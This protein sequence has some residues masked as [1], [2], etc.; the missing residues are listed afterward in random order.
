VAFSRVSTDVTDPLF[1]VNAS[2]T[3]SVAVVGGADLGILLES[4]DGGAL[5]PSDLPQGTHQ[6]YGVWLTEHGGYAVG[7]NAVVLTRGATRWA[8]VATG[9]ETDGAL[10]AV[11]V[12]ST[13]GVWSVGGNLAAP[14]LGDGIMLHRGNPV[15]SSVVLDDSD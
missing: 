4:A 13:D 11:W 6:L 7:Q 8:T 3:G 9:I 5:L 10:H 2:A 15:P 14:P 12:D 1:T